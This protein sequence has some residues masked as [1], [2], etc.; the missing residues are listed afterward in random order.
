MVYTLDFLTQRKTNQI[1]FFILSGVASPGR[2]FERAGLSAID[3]LTVDR[4]PPADC[5]YGIHT[6]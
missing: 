2:A 1:E 6:F 4:H 3:S 5:G